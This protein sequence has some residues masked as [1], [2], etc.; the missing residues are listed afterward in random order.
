MPDN[1]EDRKV[2]KRELRAASITVVSVCIIILFYFVVLRYT[3]IATGWARFCKILEPIVMGFVMAFLINPIMISVEKFLYR[4]IRKIS[5]SDKS[6]FKTTRAI[7]AIF[8]LIV[9]IGIIS[10]FIKMVVPQLIETITYLVN[11]LER[12]IAAVLDWCNLITGGR[13]EKTLMSAKDSPLEDA[14]QEGLNWI[15]QYS[16]YDTNALI[17]MTTSYVIST[18]KS[19]FNLCIGFFVAIYVLC[20]KEK[21]KGQC[22]KIICAS[23]KPKQA[24]TV[25]EISRK[26]GEIFYGF[27]I[28]KIIDSIIIGIICYIC[29]LIFKFPYP[30][31]VS[32]IV[33]VTNV[34]PVFGPY[35]GAIPTTL[36]IFFTEPMK[37]I[38]FLIFILV[39]QQFDGNFLGPKILGNTTGLSSFWVVFAVVVGGGLFGIVGMVIGVPLVAIIYYMLSQYFKHAL[40]KKGLPEETR[41]YTNLKEIDLENNSLV[42]LTPEDIAA[43]EEKKH[44]LF[45]HQKEE[46]EEEKSSENNQ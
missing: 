38:Y 43:K 42:M 46:T 28:G 4:Y 10:L 16:K 45:S 25:L 29:C 8:G 5:K 18:G 7:A 12:Q 27:I 9:L 3:G 6:A 32:V 31:L 33:G 17:S 14:F 26:A 23:L 39:L 44:K 22:K 34:I 11:N 1:S 24:N 15:K 41:D 37:G 21:F 35:I 19:F 13:Y 30:V 36:I 40:N 20:D 2:L